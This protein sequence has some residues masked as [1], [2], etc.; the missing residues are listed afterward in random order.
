MSSF[1]S[2]ALGLSIAY[3][4]TFFFWPIIVIPF[5]AFGMFS[6]NLFGKVYGVIVALI[7]GLIMYIS[8]PLAT[9]GAFYHFYPEEAM[10]TWFIVG[11]AIAALARLIQGRPR[12]EFEE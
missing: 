11:F 9:Y 2:F 7:L 12:L 10:N 6:L 8:I 5:T 1:I 3:F 4:G